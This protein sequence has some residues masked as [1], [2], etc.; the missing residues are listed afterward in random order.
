MKDSPAPAM[1]RTV[2]IQTASR[3][4]AYG[5]SSSSDCCGRRKVHSS[6]SPLVLQADE[7]CQDSEANKDYRNVLEEARKSVNAQI[8]PQDWQA[9]L[10]VDVGYT[11][12]GHRLV[13]FTPAFLQHVMGDPTELDQA[14]KFIVFVME[15]VVKMDNY[16]FVYCHSG[17]TLSEPEVAQRL[18]LAYD[19]LPRQ[20]SRRLHRFI[21][22]HATG[23]LRLF[24][25][26][27]WAWML[28]AETW[29]KVE[30]MNS[31]DTL[32]EEIFPTNTVGRAKTRRRFPHSVLREDA[33]W[34]GKTPPVVFGVSLQSLCETSSADVVDE[35]NGRWYPQLPP[36]VLSLCD[37]LE[38]RSGDEGFRQMF[39][40]EGPVMK[41]LL[42]A[43]DA[44]LPLD[45][46]LPDA[47]LWCALKLFLDRMPAPLFGFTAFTELGA[48]LNSERLQV[49]DKAGQ[50]RYLLEVLRGK[51]P[52]V[53]VYVTM[54]LASFFLKMCNNARHR[55]M[56]SVPSRADRIPAGVTRG[57]F[58]KMSLQMSADMSDFS[59]DEAPVEHHLTPKL[60]AE[61]FT[62]GF[63]RPRALT[64]EAMRVM[65]VAKSILQTLICAAEDSEFV[66]KKQTSTRRRRRMASQVALPET[67]SDTEGDSSAVTSNG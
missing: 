42:A 3:G 47:A 28:S 8:F 16:I 29:D 14:F 23:G 37:A 64:R 57:E 45:P 52:D 19:I 9:Q 67:E 17:N 11:E 46:E 13:L 59:D 65:P 36:A 1:S 22:L 6:P 56:S 15:R 63:L 44:G 39:S 53:A 60:V 25:N 50:R 27:T 43:L 5:G 21:I 31:L 55:A 58:S 20:Y 34:R 54:F 51:V 66:G 24:I 38:H 62:P 41:D 48:R 12:Q 49:S 61:V 2:T 40:V 30:Y 18:R 7:V 33:A 32:C 35:A 26:L 4:T 10:L